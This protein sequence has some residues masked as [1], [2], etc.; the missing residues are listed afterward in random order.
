MYV[1]ILFYYEQ[2]KVIQISYFSF[3]MTVECR[4]IIDPKQFPRFNNWLASDK[5]L[6]YR[7]ASYQNGAILFYLFNS[8]FYQ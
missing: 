8:N 2:V 5:F 3:E 1:F 4:Q 7:I 6:V